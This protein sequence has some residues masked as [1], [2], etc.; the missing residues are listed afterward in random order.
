MGGASF[1]LSYCRFLRNLMAVVEDRSARAR[2]S[3]SSAIVDAIVAA[4]VTGLAGL[5]SGWSR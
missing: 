1:F 2:R 3:V 5:P 4:V